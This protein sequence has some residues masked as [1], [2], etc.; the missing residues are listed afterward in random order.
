M[1]ILAIGIH[2]DDVELGCGGTVARCADAGHDVVVVD[3][4]AGESS[5]NGTVEQRAEEAREAARILGAAAR[6]CL[7]LPDTRLC[8]TDDAQRRAVVEALRR[9]RADVALVPSSDDPHPDHAEGGRLVEAALY[10]AGI[11]G[12]EPSAGDAW[13]TPLA[14][15]YGGRRPVR[16]VIV[17]DVT[18]VAQRKH[19]A[20]RAHASQ[21]GAVPGARPTPLNAEGFLDA[22]VGRERETGQLAGV[23][24][25]EAFEPLSPV[26]VADLARLVDRAP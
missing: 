1:K 15:R 19:E 25:A 16:P 4:T 26:V 3:L 10:L 2:P 20:I 5:T 7:G 21:F 17:V 24:R 18:P 9:H 22:V 14:L 6:E 11:A 13:K 23:A 12:C 8:A